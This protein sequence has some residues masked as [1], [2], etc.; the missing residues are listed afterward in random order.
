MFEWLNVVDAEAIRRYVKEKKVGEGT[1][2]A[3]YEGRDTQTGRRVALKKI[4]MTL[5]GAGLDISAI[6]ELR[7][8]YELR[9]PN[10]AE[11]RRERI[12][13]VDVSRWL[14]YLRI[15]RI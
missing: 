10:V 15:R 5:H 11:V 1:Y 4:K 7:Y 2:A 13:M 14:M 12:C 6:R 3:V 9:H 8:L